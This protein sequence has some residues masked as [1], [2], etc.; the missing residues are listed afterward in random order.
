[1][2][3]KAKSARIRC[4]IS[5]SQVPGEEREDRKGE[6]G[7]AEEPAPPEPAVI[8]APAPASLDA[9]APASLDAAAPASLDV[10][11]APASLDAAAPASLDAAAAP[12]PLD[13]APAPLDVAAAPAPLDA[14]PAPLDA[15]PA[16]LDAAAA[17]DESPLLDRHAFDRAIAKHLPAL[18][19]RAAQLCRGYGD[20]DDLVQDALLRAFRA[21]SQTRDLTRLRGWLLT[22]VTN[23]FLD[24]LRRRKARPGEVELEIDVPAPTVEEDD[25]PWARIDLDDIRAA[26]A[27]LPDDVR[28]AYRLFA[29]E[30]N[31]YTAV[32]KQ[33]R[34][35]KATV[36][37]RI[38]R[39]RKRLRALLLR[40]HIDPPPRV[41]TL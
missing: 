5:P 41:P 16:P 15:A 32:S 2:P 29:L 6:P 31:D 26:V 3:G 33:L 34:I 18:R 10:A 37:T 7:S 36:G 30:G 24:S 23:T 39:A 12:A 19:A 25:S 21:R 38:L 14:A 13:A 1:M 4:V 35:P 20:P 11:A 8:D 17:P 27:E 40:K 22:I 28:E 9:A